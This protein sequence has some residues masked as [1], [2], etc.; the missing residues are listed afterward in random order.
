MTRVPVS[1]LGLAPRLLAAIMTVVL[2]AGATAWTVASLIG[3]RAFHHHMVQTTADFATIHH[4]ERAFSN[5]STISLGLAL[6]AGLITSLVVSGFLTGRI[7]SALHRVQNATRQVASGDYSARVPVVGMGVEFDELAR[8]FNTMAEDLARIETTRVQMLSDLAHE[9]RTP[10]ATLDAYTQAITE[11]VQVADGDTV[12]I[13]RDQ[14]HRLSRLA[15]DISLVTAAE[16][17]RLGL[18][19]RPLEIGD[20]ISAAVSQAEDRF[21]DKSVCLT[22]DAEPSALAARV[23]GDS[24]RLG[25]TLT[26]LL[27]NALRHTPEQ[28]AVRITLTQADTSVRLAI[29]DTGEGIAVEHLPH[30]FERFYRVDTARDRPHGGSGIGLAIVRSIVQHH[31]GTVEVASAGP[32]AG[33]TFTIT[34]PI[35]T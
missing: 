16:E 20:V 31:G 14:I 4:A 28:G 12:Q 34:L 18:H 29:S 3:P 13:L 30:L 25:Q 1:S 10:V 2:V 21:A 22:V 6:L 35:A 8:D 7:S 24:D 27:D 23:E 26:N 15:A 33:A 17:G 19:L 5:S 9:M 32:G 11:G